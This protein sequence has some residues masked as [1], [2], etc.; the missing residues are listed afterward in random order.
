MTVEP[1]MPEFERIRE[2]QEKQLR[3]AGVN[4][5]LR[6]VAQKVTYAVG[7]RRRLVPVVF[8]F[9]SLV[10]AAIGPGNIAVC[11]LVLPIALA[12]S[13]E[14]KISALPGVTCRCL[15]ATAPLVF[16]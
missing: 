12:V 6:L 2:H 5:T 15:Y 11:A 3:I 10:L 9:M 13:S 7:G 14:E 1:M 4:G 16:F 8:F